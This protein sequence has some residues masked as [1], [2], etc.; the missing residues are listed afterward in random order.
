MRP[1]STDDHP[2]VVFQQHLPEGAP[3][4]V[5]VPV[6]EKDMVP[7]APAAVMASRRQQVAPPQPPRQVAASSEVEFT[8]ISAPHTTAGISS[9]AQSSSKTD[10]DVPP[11]S[12]A[13]LVPQPGFPVNFIFLSLPVRRGDGTSSW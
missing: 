12:H 7:S 4:S 9:K 13:G 11:A 3:A 1:V 10:S 5:I 8:V 2:H 6:T